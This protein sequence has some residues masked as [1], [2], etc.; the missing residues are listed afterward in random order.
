MGGYRDD[1]YGAGSDYD[2]E[3]DGKRLADDPSAVAAADD[4]HRRYGREGYE[5][6]YGQHDEPYRHYRQRQIEEL[7][8]DYADWR[9]EREQQFHR[10]YDSWRRQRAAGT[11]IDSD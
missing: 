2:D 6:S 1:G 11:N 8:R 7:D 5:G 10:E 4:W 3:G 9:R